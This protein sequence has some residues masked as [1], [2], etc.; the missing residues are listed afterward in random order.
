MLTAIFMPFKR[1][2]ERKSHGAASDDLAGTE[3][4]SDTNAMMYY[5]RVGTSQCMCQVNQC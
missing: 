4:D 1:Y 3:T 5:H 2:P